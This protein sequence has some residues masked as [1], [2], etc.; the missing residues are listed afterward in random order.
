MSFLGRRRNVPAS[1]PSKGARAMGYV[2]DDHAHTRGPGAI[3]AVDGASMLRRQRQALA[4][5][6]ATKRDRALSRMTLGATAIAA[7]R[8]TSLRVAPQIRMVAP[9]MT[10]QPAVRPGTITTPTTKYPGMTRPVAR[11]FT[12][13]A[14]FNPL[15]IGVVAMPAT[16]V[17]RTGLT[18][19]FVTPVAGGTVPGPTPSTTVTPRNDPTWYT[20]PVLP[21]G[22]LPG[23]PSTTGT[24]AP[25]PPATDP[26]AGGA[27]GG[28]GTMTT[29]DGGGGGG[30][31]AGVT[32]PSP[33][34]YQPSPGDGSDDSGDGA[35]EDVAET[36]PVTTAPAPM[37]TTKMLV[38]GAALAGAWWLF[39]R[40]E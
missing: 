20:P 22:G 32:T 33:T 29:S 34:P 13:G 25:T 19:V 5:R 31:G 40:S 12:G 28:S 23:R 24:P 4:A 1:G 2:R 3:A 9:G 21:P 7:P 30:G 14:G 15:A 36:G 37:S 27:A 8:A 35:A 38:I 6:I 11:P 26:S 17:A 10:G 39:G 18:R 16:G